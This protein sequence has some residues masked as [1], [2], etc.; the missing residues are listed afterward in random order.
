MT[1]IPE[2]DFRAPVVLTNLHDKDA[3]SKVTVELEKHLELFDRAPRKIDR[4]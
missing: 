3:L 4:Q 2:V 1:A